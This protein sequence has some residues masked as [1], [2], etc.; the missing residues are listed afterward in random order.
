MGIKLEDVKVKMESWYFD[1]EISREEIEQAKKEGVDIANLDNLVKYHL[2]NNIKEFEE[3]LVL[4]DFEY[5]I[6]EEYFK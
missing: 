3:K 2:L 6:T 5:D 4:Q 1:T